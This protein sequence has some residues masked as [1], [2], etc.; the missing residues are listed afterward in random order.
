[1]HTQYLIQP[2]APQ[3]PPY[4]AEQMAQ[5]LAEQLAVFLFPLLVT[6]D[7]L[8]DKPESLASEDLCAVRSSKAKRLTHIKPGYYNP[9]GRPIFVPG[10]HWLAVI[11]V[12]RSAQLGPPLL[13]AMR[14][15][16]SRGAQASFKRDEEGKLL[17]E[18]LLGWGRSVVHTFD[19][20]FA[21]A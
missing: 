20:G 21:G 5:G 2:E 15:W 18:R 19:Q 14:W 3:V 12:G 16:S 7:Q 1:M 4:A 11:V 9:P 17:V 10:L 6:L 13:A 8:L